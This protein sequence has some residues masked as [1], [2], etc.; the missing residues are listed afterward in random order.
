MLKCAG[1]CAFS[2]NGSKKKVIEQDESRCKKSDAGQR[3]NSRLFIGLHRCPKRTELY[4]RRQ[5][6][7]C[8]N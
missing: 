7:R 2:A 1:V 8:R 3:R 6:S 5:D 4:R